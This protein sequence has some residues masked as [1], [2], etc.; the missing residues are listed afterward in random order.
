MATRSASELWPSKSGRRSGWAPSAV[1]E[2]RSFRRRNSNRRSLCNAISHGGGERVGG[3]H[4]NARGHFRLQDVALK[5]KAGPLVL[6]YPGASEIAE[7]YHLSIS[8]SLTGGD[9]EL[10]KVPAVGDRT[11]PV[12]MGGSAR[13]STGE[14][15]H[16]VAV[17]RGMV[18]CG[19]VV[20]LDLAELP[21][22]IT[23]IP[24]Q[25][26]V[27]ELPAHRPQSGAPRMDVTA[28]RAA[29]S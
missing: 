4:R 15:Q 27:E 3:S 21:L 29:R 25:H 19:V 22:K 26:M 10:H 17:Q 8:N 7:K 16:R 13:P 18:A 28:A 14:R 12:Q 6:N 5:I 11:H 24:K 9:W 2:S 23:A 1:I 20:V